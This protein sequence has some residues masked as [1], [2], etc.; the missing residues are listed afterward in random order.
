MQWCGVNYWVNTGRVPEEPVGTATSM[1]ECTE[2]CPG[3]AF[4]PFKKADSV[5]LI[6]SSY[7]AAV[8]LFFKR[9]AGRLH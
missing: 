1:H 7:G 8:D 5:W 4:C 9:N 6:E 3:F 2:D